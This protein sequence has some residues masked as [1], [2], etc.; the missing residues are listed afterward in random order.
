[1]MFATEINPRANEIINLPAGK[2]ILISQIDETS[3]ELVTNEDANH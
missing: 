2:S 1:M 3:F